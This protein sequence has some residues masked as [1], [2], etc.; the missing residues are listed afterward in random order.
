MSG[1][2]KKIT[3]KTSTKRTIKFETNMVELKPD[4]EKE[5]E[6]GIESEIELKKES[7][8]ELKEEIGKL[9]GVNKDLLKRIPKL[10]DE[11]RIP[12]K[13]TKKLST[14]QIIRTSVEDSDDDEI[15]ND[16]E[17]FNYKFGGEEE[18]MESEDESNIDKDNLI[19]EYHNEKLVYYD[20]DKNIVYDTKYRVIGY[21]NDEGEIVI[22]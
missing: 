14:K 12:K 19:E 2:L 9:M 3:K 18:S 10:H 17:L 15:V 22:S 20:P 5:K 16:K 8:I 6:Y 11:M 4:L 1:K 7:E 13:K 21:V